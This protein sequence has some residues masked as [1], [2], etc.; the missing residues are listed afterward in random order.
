[1]PDTR[2]PA[3]LLS[4]LGL[5]DTPDWRKAR[6]LG[7]LLG[8]ALVL[9][10]V[11]ALVAAFVLVAR[12]IFG[13][14]AGLGT[15]ALIVALLGAP[16]LIW[17]TVL[18]HQTVLW[19]K[20]GHM[21]DRISKA[22]EQLGAEKTV[23]RLVGEQTVETTEPNLEVRIGAILSLERIAQDST[24]HDRGRDHVRVM[25]ILCAY[26]RH[27]AP[28]SGAQ[29]HEFGD[30]EPL[31]DDATPEDRAAREK[32]RVE[33]FGRFHFFNGKVWAWARTLTPP[34]ADIAE[35][36][37]VI[38]RR[39]RD[40]MRV[41]AAWPDPPDAGTRWPFKKECPTLPD[42]PRDAA[43]TASEL[44]AWRTR[45]GTW[46][47]HIG[48]YR[49][50]RIDLRST[51]LQGAD[52]S[53]AHLQA[54]R[55]DRARMEGASLYQARMEGASLDGAR[56]E[57]ASL[58]EARMQGANLAGAR[59]EGASLHEA[60]MQGAILDLARMEGASLDQARM[61]GAHLTMAR[62]EGASLDEARMEGA[63]LDGVRMNAF[64]VLSG[65]SFAMARFRNIDLSQIRL[66]PGQIAPAFGDAT[67]TLPGGIA[68]G[69][70][71]WPAH[72]PVWKLP[73]LGAHAFDAEWEKWR[74]NPAAYRP[75][76]P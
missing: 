33:R 16:V 26:I 76:P 27:N 47:R 46:L 40:Q 74:A 35:A 28:A 42:K 13:A 54:A 56:M 67:V 11:L 8:F 70:P 1:M 21:T 64:T 61:E 44:A 59:M 75:P 9:L 10:I 73:D 53:G 23:K 39:S 43:R 14:E 52:L 69:H 19:Q 36:L 5:S 49:G 41:E 37:K 25:E 72:W 31:S 30:W 4:W 68:P 45:L 7:A 32:A 55:L 34:R 3:T 60:W 12:T 17:T 29:D 62:M 22:V 48:S 50:Y 65:T 6:P 51:N 58:S 38:A 63:S 2:E 66:I 71:G 15:G 24:R 18:K 57:G 20:E